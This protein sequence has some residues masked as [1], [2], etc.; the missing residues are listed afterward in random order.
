MFTFPVDYYLSVFAA[1]FGVIQIAASVGRLHAMLLF[2][3]ARAT[4]ALGLGLAVGAFVYFFATDD[5]NIN[6]Y[7]GGLDANIQA[8]LFFLGAASAYVATLMLSS[9]VNARMDRGHLEPGEGLEALRHTSFGRAVSTS[10]R[11]WWREWRRQI[12]PYFFG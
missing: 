6:D 11:Y 4:H 9:L 7:E 1:S 12:R 8:L 2:R 10:L 3:S 5:R